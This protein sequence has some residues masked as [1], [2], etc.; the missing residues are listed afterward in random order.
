MLNIPESGTFSYSTLS[1][2]HDINVGVVMTIIIIARIIII[3]YNKLHE[4]KIRVTRVKYIN[5]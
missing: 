5:S 1:C 2:R 3:N 4:T